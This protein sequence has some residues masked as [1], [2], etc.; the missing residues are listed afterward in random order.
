M[1]EKNDAVVPEPVPVPVPEPEPE[2]EP[3]PEPEFELELAP[4]PVNVTAAEPVLGL[5]VVLV[6]Q[7]SLG[8]PEPVA[9]LC[10]Q[11]KFSMVLE[12]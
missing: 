1:V 4:V 7:V 5:E 2:P 8:K 3:V 11:I 9:A 10:V 6:E 12:P